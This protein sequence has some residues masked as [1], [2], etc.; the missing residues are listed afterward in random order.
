MLMSGPVDSLGRN[1]SCT[2]RNTRSWPRAA[3]RPRRLNFI[4]ARWVSGTSSPETSILSAN[5]RA[6]RLRSAPFTAARSMPCSTASTPFAALLLPSSMAASKVFGISRPSTMRTIVRFA[7]PALSLPRCTALLKVLEVT[8]KAKSTDSLTPRANC[9]A[10][11][12]TTSNRNL[13]ATLATASFP[14]ISAFSMI[15]FKVSIAWISAPAKIMRYSVRFCSRSGKF[16]CNVR[17][18]LS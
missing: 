13:R 16:F 12:P 15:S 8:V 3:T 10:N 11:L 18:N 1:A 17:T 2:R 7:S 6:R 14:W 9:I 5:R 4:L